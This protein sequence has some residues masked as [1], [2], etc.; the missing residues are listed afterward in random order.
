[1]PRSKWLSLSSG[2]A[3]AFVFLALIPGMAADQQAVQQAAGIGGFLTK[4]ICLSALVGLATF[5]GVERIVSTK[6]QQQEQPPEPGRDGAFLLAMTWFAVINVINGYLLVQEHRTL[7]DLALFFTA[8]ALK[9]VVSD[10]GLPQAHQANCDRVGKWIVIAA[11]GLGWLIGLVT[12]VHPV[13]VGLVRGFLA[14]GVILNVLKEE[15]AAERKA[16]YWPSSSEPPSTK[17]SC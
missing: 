11:L 6:R 3:V 1:M 4:N 17:H 10:Y 9:F 13:I 16:E 2:M 8:M 5:Y 7:A 14:G 12:D 15:V